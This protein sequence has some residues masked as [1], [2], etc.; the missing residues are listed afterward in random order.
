MCSENCKCTGC[1]NYEGG[2]E[3]KGIIEGQEQQPWS[4]LA[5]PSTPRSQF[6]PLPSG[7]RHAISAL[8]SDTP[9][10]FAKVKIVDYKSAEIEGSSRWTFENALGLSKKGSDSGDMTIVPRD[11]PGNVNA[12][13]PEEEKK[14]RGSDIVVSCAG[15]F[16]GLSTIVNPLGGQFEGEQLRRAKSQAYSIIEQ[17]ETDPR[18]QE[19]DLLAFFIETLGTAQNAP[20]GSSIR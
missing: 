16:T 4:D 2:P 12:S 18:R 11:L 20:V 14:H 19:K 8:R 3:R 15:T 6:T 5:S 7:K 17:G 1:K 10:A 13:A 9:L